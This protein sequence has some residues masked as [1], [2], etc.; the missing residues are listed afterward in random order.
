MYTRSKS[1]K[2]ARDLRHAQTEAEKRLWG[3]LRDSRLQGWKFRRQVPI[4]PFFVDFLCEEAKLA[5][6]VDGATHGSADEASYDERRTQYLQSAGFE[7]FRCN[8]MD[9]FE[10][11]NGVLDG[12]LLKLRGH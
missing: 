5:V 1:L 6:E 2:R 3:Y 8:N 9:V 12:L 7:V 11:L 4:G 10:N